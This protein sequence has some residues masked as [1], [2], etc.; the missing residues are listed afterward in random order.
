M[1]CWG[2]LVEYPKE[3][4]YLRGA[5]CGALIGVLTT[6]GWIWY[7]AFQL[8]DLPLVALRNGAGILLTTLSAVALLGAFVLGLPM[9]YARTEG[10]PGGS[11]MAMY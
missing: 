11:A 6:G 1:S 10:L 9:V 5:V 8:G 4:S 7:F 2:G 3:V